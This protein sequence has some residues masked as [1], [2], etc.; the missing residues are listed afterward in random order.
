MAAA[1]ST[2]AVG[3]QT[4]SAS[5][6]DLAA[7]AAGGAAEWA[8]ALGWLKACELQRRVHFREWADRARGFLLA[9]RKRAASARQLVAALRAQIRDRTQ[10]DEDFAKRLTKLANQRDAAE[11]SRASKADV[12]TEEDR[13]DAGYLTEMQRHCA[14]MVEQGAR[15]CRSA[16]EGS[17]TLARWEE[18]CKR[19]TGLLAGF[20]QNL[21]AAEARQ[22]QC[23]NFWMKHETLCRERLQLV[24]A[25]TSS[26]LWMSEVGFRRAVTAFDV[27]VEKCVASTVELRREI[28]NSMTEHRR[29]V[30][31]MLR[32]VAGCL[33]SAYGSVA[34]ACTPSNGSMPPRLPGV[35]TSSE[36]SA[37]LEFTPLPELSFPSLPCSPFILR[38]GEVER[39]P[40]AFSVFSRWRQHHMILTID[41]HVHCFDKATAVGAEDPRWSM[42]PSTCAAL[43]T[44]AAAC[45]LIFLPVS[46]WPW[47]TRKSRVVRFRNVDG[48]RAW[49]AAL[50]T[51]WPLTTT[52]SS[53]P[54]E[55]ADVVDVSRCIDGATEAESDATDMRHTDPPEGGCSSSSQENYDAHS[56]DN[57]NTQTGT[58]DAE[59]ET[60]M[61]PAASLE[62]PPVEEQRVHASEVAHTDGKC[63]HSDEEVVD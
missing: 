24:H 34:Q 57:L 38:Q 7:S 54:N 1:S 23:A 39:P 17:E 47:S 55:R 40:K 59:G 32:D 50:R 12:W 29:L 58:T 21:K 2:A 56:S 15:A 43:E 62:A 6:S 18:N 45:T 44:D 37:P 28:T 19:V 26:D 3:A 63:P 16:L 42:S 5:A 4:P 22:G 11:L 53:S 27:E 33:A 14:R 31:Q 51:W 35:E 48:F 10:A 13:A 61:D 9:E 20:E 36:A 8:E 30:R 25:S 52:T 60:H 41:G 49:E 46:S